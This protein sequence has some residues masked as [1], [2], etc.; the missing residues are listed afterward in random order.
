MAHR[1]FLPSGSGGPPRFFR[2]TADGPAGR[3]RT[4][5][6]PGTAPRQRHP[7]G[8]GPWAAEP[9]RQAAAWPPAATT[10]REARETLAGVALIVRFAIFVAAI[11]AR[12]HVGRLWP[13]AARREGWPGGRR[14]APSLPGAAGPGR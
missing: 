3:G 4:A 6:C 9:R 12:H 5:A 10:G 2:F 11:L 1:M 13:S 8:R 14:A 7:R